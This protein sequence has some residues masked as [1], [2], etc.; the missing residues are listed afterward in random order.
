MQARSSVGCLAVRGRAII[1]VVTMLAAS[2][3][4][5]SSMDPVDGAVP[6]VDGAGP[7]AGPGDYAVRGSALGVLVPVDLELRAGGDAE[8]LSVTRDGAFAFATRLAA[9]TSYTVSL[10][11][12]GTPCTLGNEAGVI[13]GADITVELT[14]AGASLAS[15]LVSGVAPVVTL[16]PGTTDYVVDVPLSN[17]AVTL[18]ATVAVPGDTLT[19]AGSPVPSGTPSAEIALDSSDNFVDIVVENALGWQRTYRFNLRRASQLAQY[20]YAKASNAGAE[21][22]FGFSV[23]VSGDTLVVG[24]R[25]EDSAA[26]GVDGD[27]R[28]DL[29]HQESGAVYVFRRAGTTWQQE[30]YLKASNTGA[31][32]EFGE[33]VAIS[34]D[35]LVV[36]A[37]HEDS[38]AQGVGGDQ[39][40][41]SA[42]DS[43]AVY[44]F[45]RTGTTWQQEAY[46][47]ASNTDAGDQFGS[48]VALS[49]DTLAVGALSEDSAARGVGN[50]QD[51]DSASGSGAVYVF[52]RTGTTWQQEAYLKASNTDAADFFGARVALSGDTLAVGAT[53]E[54]G[55]GGDE[56]DNTA[57]ASGAVYVFRRT[58]TTWQQEAY[59]KASNVDTGD[60]FGAS[61]ALSGD[62]LAV[63]AY[64]EDS[65]ARGVNGDAADNGATASGA[66]Y[67]FRRTGATWQQEAYVKASNTAADDQLGVSVGLAG[68]TLA[69]GAFSEDSAAQGVDGNQDDDSVTS[70]GAVY[71]LRRKGTIWEHTA[72]LKAS[73]TGADDTFSTVALSGDTLAVGASLEDSASTGVG[74]AQA[75]ES[76]ANAG[77]VYV[78]H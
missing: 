23:A 70:S 44:V 15:L 46:L 16:V 31:N 26:Q 37:R 53:A 5:D 28:D 41:D 62:T 36:G 29:F 76:S 34:G 45:R 54:D 10:V 40:D 20:A 7:D 9:G 74:G 3:G 63:G 66:V 11:D 64:L 56:D 55:A 12:P 22:R 50:G 65:A 24:A 2:C 17:P 61:V 32:D 30:A 14:C 75:D 57:S 39:A 58:G 18:T 60:L 47:K 38:A 59:L 72:Y 69:V 1:L 52:R 21:D 68:D 73:N 78:F 13:A 77:A 48:S 49:G 71:V 27:P 35:T 42:S 8:P 51:D 33:T 25:L 6:P 67:V 19:I 43:G 4:D